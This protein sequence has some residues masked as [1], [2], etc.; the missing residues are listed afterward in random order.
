MDTRFYTRIPLF[1]GLANLISGA[2]SSCAMFVKYS[3]DIYHFNPAGSASKDWKNISEDMGIA[4]FRL[5]ELTNA[6]PQKE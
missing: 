4:M 3:D 1:D 6:T 5:K 2:F